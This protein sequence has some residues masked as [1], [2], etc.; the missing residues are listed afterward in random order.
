[1]DVIY[2]DSW[3]LLIYDHETKHSQRLKVTQKSSFSRAHERRGQIPK[4]LVFE[5]VRLVVGGRIWLAIDIIL[6]LSWKKCT[7]WCAQTTI[8]E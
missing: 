2:K 4:W 3:S 5:N 8:Y 6:S 7:R 1:M